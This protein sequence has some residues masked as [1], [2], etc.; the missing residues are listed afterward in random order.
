MLKVQSETDR[1]L[2]YLTCFQKTLFFCYDFSM[3]YKNALIAKNRVELRAWLTEHHA[4]E[5][6]CWV[7]V[8]RGKP[9]V[10]QTFWY[11]DAVEEALCFGWIDSVHKNTAEY[12][13]IQKL[14][15]RKKN[16]PW[17]ELNK[18]RVRR[19]EKLGL[20]TDAGRAVLPDMSEQGFV[21]DSEI[22]ALLQSDEQTWRNFQSFPPLYQRV[23]VDAV[24]R[25][26]GK[27]GKKAVYE[28]TLAK[29]IENTRQ[30]I[31]YGEWNDGGRLLEY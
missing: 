30:G 31:M 28:S 13:H 15:P 18:E 12:G 4:T 1:G 17:S 8:N 22:L 16:S 23:R 2:F 19:L 20:M 7:A 29:L 10:D 9:K 26:K 3:E 5:A 11:L 24:Q 21:I 27:S 25:E 14:S 6:E